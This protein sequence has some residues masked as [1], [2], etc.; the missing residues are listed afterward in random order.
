MIFSARERKH[1]CRRK[2]LDGP[3]FKKLSRQ[4]MNDSNEKKKLAFRVKSAKRCEARQ[5][6]ESADREGA[7]KRKPGKARK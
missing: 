3:A 6:L 1:E 4:V 7:K 2:E 5:T